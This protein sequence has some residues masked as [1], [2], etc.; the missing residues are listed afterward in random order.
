MVITLGY[1]FLLAI[2]GGLI[3]ICYAMLAE[4]IDDSRNAGIERGRDRR[5]L[6]GQAKP[7][8]RNTG[9]RWPGRNEPLRPQH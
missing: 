1:A 8:P 5:L 4:M 6:P 3:A 9:V 2:A 7:L